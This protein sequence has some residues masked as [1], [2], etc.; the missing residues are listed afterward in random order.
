MAL[1]VVG[2]G[3]MPGCPCGRR[4]RSVHAKMGGK[5]V[6]VPM[7]HADARNRRQWCFIVF[8]N[9][10]ALDHDVLP[11][12]IGEPEPMPLPQPP[13]PDPS[14]SREAQEG[15]LNLMAFQA[16]LQGVFLGVPKEYGG[17][18]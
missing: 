4:V 18:E 14:R 6:T 1:F 13:L 11:W 10:A 5:R 9:Y 3:L 12:G 16:W 17:P 15:V 2:V 7:M 8:S